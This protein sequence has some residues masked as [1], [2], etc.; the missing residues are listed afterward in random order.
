MTLRKPR[1]PRSS[2]RLLLAMSPLCLSAC[3]TALPHQ[4]TSDTCPPEVRPTLCVV[5]WLERP[6][7]PK[8]ACVIQWLDSVDRQQCIL[9]GMTAQECD[10]R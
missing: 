1:R 4:Q 9:A 10:L 6:I 8:P 5:D 7:N 2:W 3:A